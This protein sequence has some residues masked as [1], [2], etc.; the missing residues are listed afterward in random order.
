MITPKRK[1]VNLVALK[2][3]DGASTWWEQVEVNKR[4]NDKRLT[5]SWEKIKKLMK[6]IFLPSNYKQTLYNQYQGCHKGVDP[7]LNIVRNSTDWK[8]EQT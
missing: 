3:K 4:R 2:L 7:W 5:M 8:L 1:K 6:T